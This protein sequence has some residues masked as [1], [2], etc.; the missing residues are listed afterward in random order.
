MSNRELIEKLRR[1]PRG[2][3]FELEH[4]CA[5]ALEKAE[6][7]LAAIK[8]AQPDGWVSEQEAKIKR[9]SEALRDFATPKQSHYECEDA[10]Y[11]CPKHEGYAKD[12]GQDVCNCGADEHNARLELHA[13][14]LRDAGVK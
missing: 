12:D 3:M 6:A 4:E 5:D 14:A 9:L 11:S 8:A 2:V 1:N 7:E 13:A 10:W